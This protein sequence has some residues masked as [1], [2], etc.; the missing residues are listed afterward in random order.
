MSK[1]LLVRKRFKVGGENS[2]APCP[3]SVSFDQIVLWDL[4]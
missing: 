4:Q 3:G 2:L 1:T